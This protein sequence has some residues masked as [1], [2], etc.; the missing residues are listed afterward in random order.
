MG[1]QWNGFNSE[2]KLSVTCWH[3]LNTIEQSNWER[4]E[5]TIL[6]PDSTHRCQEPG[7]FM[8]EE[9]ETSLAASII[10]L[11]ANAGAK[12]AQYIRLLEKRYTVV[13]ARSGKQAIVKAER[14]QPSAI[15]LDAVS[16]RTTGERI[17]HQLAE[18]ISVPLIHIH[19]GPRSEARTSAEVILF[20]PLSAKRLFNCVE[21]LL[22]KAHDEIIECGPFIMNVPKRTLIAHGK[23]KQ[24]TPKVALLLELFMRNLNQTMD[25]KTLMEKVW[26]TDYLG[27][28]RTL[29]VHIRWVREALED[30]SRK[31]RFLKTVRGVG[32]RLV[33]AEK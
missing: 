27:D 11:V 2:I 20:P 15:V 23:E 8:K 14:R 26:Q 21:L 9:R 5:Y 7:E 25:R 32:Y 30:K 18:S 33:I 28:T 29:D 19:P 24:L 22:G 16:M 12:T 6:T 31:P 17:V 10:L 1:I 3:W 4:R 13:V